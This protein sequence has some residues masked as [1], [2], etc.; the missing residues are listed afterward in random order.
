MNAL[1]LA[2]TGSPVLFGSGGS[3][4]QGVELRH[5]RYFVAVAVADAGTFTQAAERMYIAQPTLRR[6][7]LGPASGGLLPVACGDGAFGGV[8]RAARFGEVGAGPR[9]SR[10]DR[11]DVPAHRHHRIGN[12]LHAHALPGHPVGY[13]VAERVAADQLI[14]GRD[15]VADAVNGVAAARAGWRTASRRCPGTACRPGSR[16]CGA[17]TSHGRRS[18]PAASSSTTSATRPDMSRALSLGYRQAGGIGSMPRRSGQSGAGRAGPDL[19]ASGPAAA[20]QSHLASSRRFP[21]QPSA[22]PSPWR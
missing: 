21:V 19:L 12:R 6:F 3:A 8:R 2:Q 4:P 5:L 16:C 1:N 17:A 11:R 9:S 10:R 15:V 18:C 20:V 13:V 14:A 22:D 7:P